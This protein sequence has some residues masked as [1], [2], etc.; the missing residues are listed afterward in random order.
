ML[1]LP[2][3]G[4]IFFGLMA[5][6]Q[7]VALLVGSAREC[8]IRAAGCSGNPVE[9]HGYMPILRTLS[10]NSSRLTPVATRRASSV[11]AHAKRKD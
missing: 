3:Q 8:E 5:T 1:V 9:T 2:L 4:G 11:R 7:L 6:Y 10:G